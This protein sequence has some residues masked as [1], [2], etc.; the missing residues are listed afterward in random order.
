MTPNIRKVLVT[1]AAGSIGA[2]V[3]RVLV[4]A[5]VKVIGLDIAETPLFWLAKE[6]E[7]SGDFTPVIGSV[8]DRTLL[9]D[10]VA[11]RRPQ[12][13]VHAAALKHVEMC[14]RNVCEA[15][16]VNI[17]GTMA[18]AKAARDVG[19]RMVLVSTDKAVNPTS[20]MGATKAVAEG[21]LWGVPDARIVRLVNIWESNGS[22]AHVVRD[23]IA[24][25]GP[26]TI[27]DPEMVRM[28]MS[29][30]DAARM[31]GDAVFY[32][33]RFGGSFTSVPEHVE[34]R[35]IIDVI[36]QLI[37]ESGRKDISV[38]EIGRFHGEKLEEEL[39]AEGDPRHRF[40]RLRLGWRWGA[41]LLVNMTDERRVAPVRTALFNLVEAMNK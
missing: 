8:T 19:A 9:W 32:P 25:G 40:K 5:G 3:C 12:V 29:I 22:L 15:V 2:E 17:G 16:K 6:L 34:H 23:Q 26:V 13:V 37:A 18:V 7:K 35:K 39:E 21:L 28:F 1:G 11:R 27:T 30:G 14:E 10:L 36:G 4:D 24:K 38:V 33:D 41:A 20:V 31:I